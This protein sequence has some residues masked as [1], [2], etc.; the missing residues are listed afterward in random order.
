[1]SPIG[2]VFRYGTGNIPGAHRNAALRKLRHDLEPMALEHAALAWRGALLQLSS[3]LIRA[4]RLFD[5]GNLG[6]A[7]MIR[8]KKFAFLGSDVCRANEGVIALVAHGQAQMRVAQV[9]FE[10][11]PGNVALVDTL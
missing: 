6:F 5:V 1:N 2:I 4:E 7:H 9:F 8:P 11:E 10:D 3:G